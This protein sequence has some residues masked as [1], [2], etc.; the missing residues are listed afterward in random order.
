MTTRW[1]VK[2]GI[3]HTKNNSGKRNIHGE[4]QIWEE[5]TNKVILPSPQVRMAEKQLF[6]QIV[7]DHNEA[8]RLREALESYLGMSDNLLNR[9]TLSA[10]DFEQLKVALR[11]IQPQAQAAL[12]GTTDEE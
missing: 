11:F 8:Q 6:N 2:V 1:T 9:S 4:L 7:A 5:G 3:D 12:R 10:E